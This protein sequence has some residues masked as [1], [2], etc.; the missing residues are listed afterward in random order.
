M[1]S[2][3]RAIT[4]CA[5]T[6]VLLACGTSGGGGDAGVDDD[7]GGRGDASASEGWVFEFVADP[8]LGDVGGGV[9]VD[10]ARISLRDV[11]A[12]GDSATG[13]YRTSKAEVD[14]EWSDGHTPSPLRFPLAPPGIYSTF[15]ARLGLPSTGSER[16]E[17]RGEVVVGGETRSFR[18][19]ND[20][21]NEQI[22][23]PLDG[24]SLGDEL[25][26]ATIACSFAFLATL[27]WDQIALEEGE[28]RIEPGSPHMPAVVAGLSAA[29]SLADVR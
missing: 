14:L 20:V 4:L 29:F 22:A 21:V 2:M 6:G 26:T 28:Y 11:R 23:V 7:G 1:I 9:S 15:E 18:I 8:A 17:I 3:L 5:L 25:R 19:E 24:L 13:D 10:E 27:P 16:F 12:I